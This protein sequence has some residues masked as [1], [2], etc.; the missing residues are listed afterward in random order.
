MTD[1]HK[2]QVTPEPLAAN[3][4]FGKIAKTVTDFGEKAFVILPD[5]SKDNRFGPCFWQSRDDV[6]FPIR[7]DRCI[8]QFDNRGQAWILA[9]WPFAT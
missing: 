8:V 2:E 7:G 6:T 1:Y 5:L 9:W 3:L 4:W